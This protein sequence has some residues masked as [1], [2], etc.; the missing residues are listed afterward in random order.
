MAETT[1]IHAP[2]RHTKVVDTMR[3]LL[4]I[5]GMKEGD[6]IT[7][8]YDVGCA[9]LAAKCN[10]TEAA[11]L[12]RKWEYWR[13]W[14]WHWHLLDKDFLEMLTHHPPTGRNALIDSYEY[15]RSIDA[16]L[17]RADLHSSFQHWRTR[18]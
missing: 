1:T 10:P 5:L 12:M 8:R 14:E 17:L 3:T 11:D 4:P 16:F 15:M 2:K 18:I 7:L 9:W 6:F 13:W